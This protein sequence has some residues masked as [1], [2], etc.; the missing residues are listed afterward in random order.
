MD[1]IPMYQWDRSQTY[2]NICWFLDHISNY[3]KVP[4]DVLVK[5][6]YKTL[7]DDVNTWFCSMQKGSISSFANFVAKFRTYWDFEYKGLPPYEG[8]DAQGE[9]PLQEAYEEPPIEDDSI[10]DIQEEEAL[11][12]VLEEEVHENLDNDLGINEDNDVLS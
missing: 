12:E 8:N 10:Q 1:G 9:E 2:A 7:E 6:F 5:L 11:N 3:K 4:K